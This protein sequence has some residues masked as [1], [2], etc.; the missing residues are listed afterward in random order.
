MVYSKTSYKNNEYKQELNIKKA[1]SLKQ[2][3]LFLYLQLL[4]AKNHLY[5]AL[6]G[7]KKLKQ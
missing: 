6:Q 1:V 4:N 5:K 2:Y 3:C 7:T